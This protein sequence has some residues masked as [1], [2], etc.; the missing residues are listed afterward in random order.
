MTA[1][2]TRDYL[3]LGAAA[4]GAVIDENDFMLQAKQRGIEPLEHR[5]DV[6]PLVE[7]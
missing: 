2:I 5:A 3:D 7:D 4:C 1:I 6:A